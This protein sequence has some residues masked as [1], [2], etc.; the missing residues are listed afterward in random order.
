MNEST[1]NSLMVVIEK[2]VRPVRA[3]ETR[4]LKMRE[5]LLAHLTSIYEEEFER[6]GDE[7]AA[8]EAA[9]RRFGNPRELSKE[10]QTTVPF[11]DR[12]SYLTEKLNYQP[13]ESLLHFIA[14]YMLGYAGML[15]IMMFLLLPL[16]LLGVAKDPWHLY[17]VIFTKSYPPLLMLMVLWIL[18]VAGMR[19]ALFGEDRSRG[20]AIFYG[21]LSAAVMPL[22]AFVL[23]AL[24]TGDLYGSIVHFGYACLIAP[25]APLLLVAMT[26]QVDREIR[27][28]AEWAE[29]EIG[30]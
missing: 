21:L 20:R 5:E 26:R 10:L 7:R 17:L 24:C 25:L 6:C 13:G 12:I 30:D 16:A 3:G 2:A 15:G 27:I 1:R 22:W 29:L 14:R 28:R 8:V 18:L 4:K 11:A 23:Y 9:Q 19:K